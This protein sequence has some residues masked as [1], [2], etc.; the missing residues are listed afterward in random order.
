MLWTSWLPVLREIGIR[1]LPCGYSTGG[2]L[3][4]LQKLSQPITTL[5][6]LH[7]PM[8]ATSCDELGAT[9][10]FPFALGGGYIFSSALLRRLANDSSVA[11]W[12]AAAQAAQGREGE[13]QVV[14]FSDTTMGYWLSLL[15]KAGAQTGIEERMVED[16]IAYVD[17][18]PWAHDI[19]CPGP[20]G[21]KGSKVRTCRQVNSRP[22]TSTSLIVHGLKRG[23]I[24]Y[25]F[26][27]TAAGAVEQDRARC[28]ADAF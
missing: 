28:V 24:H 26:A 22:P 20:S 18:L 17:I 12:V 13:P 27:Q 21:A 11:Q 19:C 1:S 23:G 7:K 3:G 4:A 9:P 5:F 2:L 6:D 14:F 10:P 15:T 16:A 25:A 8:S